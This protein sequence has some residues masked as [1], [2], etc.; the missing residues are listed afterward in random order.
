MQHLWEPHSAYS[1]GDKLSGCHLPALATWGHIGPHKLQ[2]P[3]KSSVHVMV[4][5]FCAA[6]WPLLM[7]CAS[8]TPCASDVVG[9]SERIWHQRDILMKLSSSGGLIPRNGRR[10]LWV[11]DPKHTKLA[12]EARCVSLIK[13]AQPMFPVKAVHSYVVESHILNTERFHTAPSSGVLGCLDSRATYGHYDG[14][15]QSTP[16]SFGE[17]CRGFEYL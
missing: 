11:A 15:W 13:S 16:R 1:D 14:D 10:K 7:F 8:F 9:N 5:S 4:V 6:V 3:K 17:N 12:S 2:K